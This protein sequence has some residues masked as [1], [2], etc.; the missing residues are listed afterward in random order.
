MIATKNQRKD[1]KWI[2]KYSLFLCTLFVP[3]MLLQDNGSA[4]Y[5]QGTRTGINMGEKVAQV[6]ITF[7]FLRTDAKERQE[8]F[9][10]ILFFCCFFLFFFFFNI[11]K[12]LDYL[13][14]K[15]K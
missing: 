8:A 10:D 11:F 3:T 15:T 6:N 4:K 7:F 12:R 14:F 9:L 1:I 2:L 5:F 13:L